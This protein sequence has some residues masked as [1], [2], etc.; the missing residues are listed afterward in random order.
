MFK[1]GFDIT[2]EFWLVCTILAAH[3]RLLSIKGL[4]Y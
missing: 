4:V 1:I 3:L 2:D